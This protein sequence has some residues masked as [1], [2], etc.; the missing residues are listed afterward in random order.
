[1]N[2][3]DDGGSIDNFGIDLKLNSIEAEEFYCE[4]LRLWF[5]DSK[6]FNTL[7]LTSQEFMINDGFNDVSVVYIDN[8][9]LRMK[10][11]VED[12]YETLISMLEF[13]AEHHKKTIE[14][15][16][17]LEENEQEAA[18]NPIKEEEEESEIESEEDSDG[19]I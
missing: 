6:G 14:V 18:S 4:T 16:N 10:S 3:V 11:L 7:S 17:Y 5:E 19:W 13:I 1:M 12:P 2:L 9:I 8:S 15:F